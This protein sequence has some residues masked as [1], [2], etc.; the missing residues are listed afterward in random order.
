MIGKLKV[1]AGLASSDHG[2][3]RWSIYIGC[4]RRKDSR[5]HRDYNHADF[6]GMRGAEICG[7]GEPFEW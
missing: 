1:E 2:M 7:L 5:E 3:A 4:D 6:E